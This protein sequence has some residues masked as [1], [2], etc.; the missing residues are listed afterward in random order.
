MAQNLVPNESF[1][2]YT[3]CPTFA[4]QLDLAAPWYNPT[5]GTPE[6]YNGCAT[7][8]SY[9]SVPEN[10]FEGYQHPRTGQAYIGIYV[11]RSTIPQMREY[12]EIPLTTSLIAG[13]CY[14]FEMWVNPHNGFQY[15]VD[16]VGAYFSAGPIGSTNGSVLGYTPQVS[17]PDGNVL[18]D[19]LNWTLVSGYFMAAGGED[20]LTI[21]NFKTDAATTVQNFNPT[22]AYTDEAYLLI[23]DLS[24]VAI[25]PS[26]LNLGPDTLLCEGNSLLLDAGDPNAQW[27]DGSV[28]ATYEVWEPGTYWATI[29]MGECSVSDTIQVDFME[30]PNVRLED[31]VA[32][33]GSTCFVDVTRE[34]ASYLWNDGS[35]EA[36]R[37]L[38]EPGTYEVTITNA[39]GSFTDAFILDFEKCF[40]QAFVPNAFTPDGSGRNDLFAPVI[41]CIQLDTYS[42]GIYNRW[43][44]LIFLSH[45]PGE[46]WD[47]TW[48]VQDCPTG[49]YTWSLFYSGTE[50]GKMVT[51]SLYGRVV[52]MR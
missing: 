1:E 19:T 26:S 3:S 20:H 17:N 15:M 21:G 40:C 8:A 47:G 16:G 13:Q 39:C 46:V 29:S 52:L 51:E 9:V 11:Y 5:M 38:S 14:Y 25:D 30:A 2:S 28:G 43:G 37:E 48:G 27:Q 44:E 45:Q 18:N 22:A 32:C 42:F 33:I 7:G 12:A 41:D 31:T 6:Y 24:L 49:V 10:L 50:E 35:T 36:E 34:N 23:D 4:S